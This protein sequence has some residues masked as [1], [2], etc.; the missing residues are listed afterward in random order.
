MRKG[1]KRAKE[2]I[3]VAN[4]PSDFII[5]DPK[6]YII[7]MR[8]TFLKK[9]RES[10]NRSLI[11]VSQELEIKEDDL[12]R[13]ESGQVNVQDMM[14]LNKLCEFYKLDY[15]SI[16]FL[17]KLAQRPERRKAEKLAAYHD[18]KIDEETQKEIMAFLSKLKDDIE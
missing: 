5:E 16:L 15:P 13:I 17:F 8:T 12:Q 11:E 3:S 14:A 4:L 10:K 9:T 7:G 2:I 1:D 6:A 18:Q